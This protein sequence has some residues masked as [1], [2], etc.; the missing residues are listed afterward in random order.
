MKIRSVATA[1]R[2]GEGLL[3][4]M[5]DIHFDNG[6]TILLSLESRMNDPQ[7]I[8]LHKNGQLTRPKTDGLRVYWRNGPS[9][10]LEEIMAITRGERL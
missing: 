10:S 2:E 8:E 6:Q 4:T 5:L 3:D 7:F 1:V 9:L